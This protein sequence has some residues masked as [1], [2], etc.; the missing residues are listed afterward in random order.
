LP[1]MVELLR[2]AGEYIK[3]WGPMMAGY[4]LASLPIV[5]L[6]ALCMRLFARGLTE[7]AEKG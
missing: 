7:G 4:A 2:L 6:F 5:I 3:Y 1:V